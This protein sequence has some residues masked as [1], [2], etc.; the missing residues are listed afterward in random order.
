MSDKIFFDTFGRR[1]IRA[2]QPYA[3]ITARA[4]VF[5]NGVAIFLE[6]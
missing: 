6:R 3:S 2:Q 1:G 5:G 4:D